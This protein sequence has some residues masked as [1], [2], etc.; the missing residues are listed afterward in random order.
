MAVIF[1]RWEEIVGPA[2]ASHVHPLRLVG[3][4]LVVG[5]DHPAWVTQVRH[6]TPEILDQLREACAEGGVPERIEVRVLR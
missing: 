2:I 1:G 4:T 6:L 3:A 5:A